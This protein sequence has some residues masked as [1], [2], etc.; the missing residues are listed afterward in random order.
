VDGLEYAL[1]RDPAVAD[2]SLAPIVSR[3]AGG[4][5]FTFRYRPGA[6]DLRYIVE[7]SIN[8]RGAVPWSEIYRFDTS[9]GVIT[10]TGVTGDENAE[11][12]VITITDSV[13]ENAQYYRLRVEGLPLVPQG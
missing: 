3:G 10:E 8:L 2:S 12:E 1:R 4:P 9:S 6:R 13:M 5:Q 11:M 7:R